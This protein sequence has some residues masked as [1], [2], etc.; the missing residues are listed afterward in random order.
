MSGCGLESKVLREPVFKGNYEKTVYQPLQ[1]LRRLNL[2][3]NLFHTL[4]SEIFE[5]MVALEW[6]D[7][8]ENP[9]KVIDKQ[10]EMAIA[11]LPHTIRV[12]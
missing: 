5:H 7:L 4:D 10:T 8:H 6:L 2:N 11:N 1:N 12:S 9:F 3:K